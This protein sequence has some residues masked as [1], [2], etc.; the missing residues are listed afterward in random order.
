MTDPTLALTRIGKTF[1]AGLA[2]S[3]VPVVAL[4]AVSGDVSA[5]EIVGVAGARGAGKTTLLRIAAGLLRADV[6]EIRWRGAAHYPPQFAAFVPT[7]AA[8]HAFLTV[9]E[10]LRFAMVQRALRETP[11]RVAEAGW[12]VRFDLVRRLDVRVGELPLAERRVVALAAAMQGMPELLVLDGM[13]DGL[14]PAARREVRR[15]LHIVS[16]SGAAVLVS[17]S[18]L[19]V[20]SGV[21]HRAAL[22]RAGRLVAWIDPRHAAPHTLLELAVGAP[23]TAAARL[24]PHVAAAWRRDG[25]VRVS[26][27]DRS[28]EEVL[29]L[30]R[31]EGIR[32]LRSRVVTEAPGRWT[33]PPASG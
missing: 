8:L 32:V 6:G 28:A 2:G 21:A 9:R 1:S 26:L 14:D 16:A 13:L 12:P 3:R 17:A 22:L 11:R 7:E 29:S 33:V 31:A 30:C 15:V 18:D 5:G 4:D 10:A 20:L 25:A 19:G 24:R 23:R 27:A